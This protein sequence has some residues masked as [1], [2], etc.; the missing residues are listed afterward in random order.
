MCR[1]QTIKCDG[2]LC[3]L[4]IETKVFLMAT[5]NLVRFIVRW[6]KR[7]A[8]GIVANRI[9]SACRKIE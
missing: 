8:D 1:F 4:N 9:A 6:I 5:N 2:N 7:L 3:T